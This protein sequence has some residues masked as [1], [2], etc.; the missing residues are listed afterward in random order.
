MNPVLTGLLVLAAWLAAGFLLAVLIGRAIA[1]G[2]RD[3]EWPRR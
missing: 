3:K 2:Q 1:Y